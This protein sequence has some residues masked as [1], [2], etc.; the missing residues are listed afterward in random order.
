MKLKKLLVPHDFSSPADVALKAALTLAEGPGGHITVLHVVSPVTGF[1]DTPMAS[2][3]IYIDPQELIAGAR[4]ELERRIA[5][6]VPKRGG[7]KVDVRVEI[8]SPYLSIVRRGAGMDAIVMST[9]GRTGLSH[10]LIGSIAE[11]VVRHAT[12][13][14]LTLR[15]KVRKPRRAR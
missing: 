2:A 7:P 11:K 15:P 13:P 3:G 6:L 5:K 4:T 10:L 8:G 14:V 1:S 9:A 12:V